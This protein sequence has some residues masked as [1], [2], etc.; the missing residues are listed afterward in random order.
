MRVFGWMGETWSRDDVYLFIYRA[1]QMA[2]CSSLW[3][4]G[5]LSYRFSILAKRQ[6]DRPENWIK[7]I[8]FYI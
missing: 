4:H 3:I 6:P 7:A 8:D 2:V 5:G 1:V